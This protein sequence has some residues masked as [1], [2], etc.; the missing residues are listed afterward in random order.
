[1]PICKL[2]FRLDYDLNYD[3]YDRP[4][5]VM[6]ILD[7]ES[8]DEFFSEKREN[9]QRRG[10]SKIYKSNDD[11]LLRQITVEPTNMFAT[12]ECVPGVDIDDLS[13]YLSFTE[14]LRI[15]DALRKE[16]KIEEVVR[17]GFRI[18]NFSKLRDSDAIVATYN[19][20]FDPGY[21]SIVRETL[22]TP[23]D[24]GLSFERMDEDGL[25]Y[26][27]KSGPIRADENISKYLE[28]FADNFSE[29]T[30]YDHIID[31]DFY[32]KNLSLAEVAMNKWYKPLLNTAKKLIT[33]IDSDIASKSDT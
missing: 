16:F 22:G 29:Q 1:M 33:K 9:Q 28:H 17:S 20:L 4:G 11:K 18:L 24:Y 15:T 2:I 32:E 10:I 21:L 3:I 5:H 25:S 7:L 12:F 23:N 19:A 26:N 30:G 27:F 8:N 31:L 14:L 6:K 13:S